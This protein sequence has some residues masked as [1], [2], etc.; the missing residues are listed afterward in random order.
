[1]DKYFNYVYITT[2]L[3][4]GKQYIGEHS[5]SNLNDDYIGSG[6]NLFKAVKK[7]GKENFNKKIIEYHKTKKDA[8]D[9]QRKY[10][11]QY[12]TLSPNGYNI[13]PAGGH[14]VKNCFSDE[15]KQKISKANKGKQPWLGK[16][17]TQKSKEKISK[18]GKGRIAWNKG[19]VGISEETRKKASDSHKNQIPW[20]IGKH[21]S[22]EHK[23]HL[24]KPKS[25]EHKKHM[26][27]PKS[28]KG[29][30]N[31]KIAHN[32]TQYL[33]KI[34]KIHKGKKVSEESRKKISIAAK[35][36]KPISKETRIKMSE[37]Q[38]RRFNK[39]V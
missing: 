27:K 2:N 13:S 11:I 35:N 32:T 26:R 30:E 23:Q 16:H 1:M 12:N 14:N 3:I 18:N 5:T 15:S 36:R 25:E 34:S 24:R 8:F 33:E 19:K 20:N 6:Y 28:E 21:L 17:H 37:S 38:K 22:E 39:K 9:A 29:K 31:I 4:D 7:Y 10:I